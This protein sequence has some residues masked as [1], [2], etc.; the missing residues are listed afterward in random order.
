MRHSGR[1]TQNPCFLP[2]GPILSYHKAV[3]GMFHGAPAGRTGG[4]RPRKERKR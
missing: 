4:A 2:A 1:F 3:M